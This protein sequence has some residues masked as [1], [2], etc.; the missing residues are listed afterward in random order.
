MPYAMALY[1]DGDRQ[2]RYM[3]G[4]RLARY[5]ERRSVALEALRADI[6]FIYPFQA[7]LFDIRDVFPLGKLSDGAQKRFFGKEGAFVESPAE[8]HSDIDGRARAAPRKPYGFDN[9]I[10]DSLD[11]L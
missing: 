7:F 4:R 1:I 10:Y 3:R 9:A 8:P 6:Q 2:P 11:T 5:A